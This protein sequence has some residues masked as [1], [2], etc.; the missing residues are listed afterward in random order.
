MTVWADQDV[1]TAA[2]VLGHLTLVWARSVLDE[3]IRK[4]GSSGQQ[5]SLWDLWQICHAGSR[6]V[7]D[8]VF[9]SGTLRT[10]SEAWIT[11]S[12]HDTDTIRP[13]M[14]HRVRAQ[15]NTEEHIQRANRILIPMTATRS[16]TSSGIIC[17]LI[18]FTKLTLGFRLLFQSLCTYM[19][20]MII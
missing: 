17:P 3:F 10:S 12:K 7:S 15:K 1:K 11:S 8:S 4:S 16:Q 20:Y 18:R 5:L 14:Q 6:K 19:V 2:D 13:E 9:W